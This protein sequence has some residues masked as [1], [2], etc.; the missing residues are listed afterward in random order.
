MKRLILLTLTLLATI[1]MRAETWHV[2]PHFAANSAREGKFNSLVEALLAAEEVHARS[3]FTSR[4][5]LTIKISPSVY[6]IDNPDDP[7][8]RKPRPGENTPFGLEVNIDHLRLIGTGR[9]AEETVVACNRGQTQGA[10][11]NFTM[12]HITGSDIYTENLTFGNYCN[13]DLDYSSNPT[14]S[15]KRRA[16][17]IVQAQL[18]ICNGDR[19]H[20]RNCRFISRLNLCPFAGARRALFEKCHFE[21]T[22][23][24]LCGT[25]VYVGCTFTFFSSKPFYATSPQGAVFLD[26]DITSLC[27]GTQY[28][29]KVASPVAMIDCRW[30]SQH[31]DLNIAWAPYP[32]PELRCYQSNVT[33]NGR[34]ILIGKNQLEYTIDVTDK[35]ILGA[36]K[37]PNNQYNI[38]NLVGG[39]DGWNPLKQKRV[40]VN[41]QPITL[42]ASHR[43]AELEADRDTLIITASDSSAVWSMRKEDNNL[44]GIINHSAGSVTVCSANSGEEPQRVVLTA[45]TP[46]GRE[47]ACAITAKPATLPAPAFRS[48]PEISRR[49]DALYVGYEIETT[50]RR[51]MSDVTW[52]RSG[53]EDGKDATCVKVSRSTQ[54]LKYPLTDA[55]EGKYVYAVVTPRH[56]RSAQ[57]GPRM[58]RIVGPL[59]SCPTE[60]RF[61]TDFTDFPSTLQTRTAPGIWTA[62]CYKPLDVSEWEW[63]VAQGD[64]WHYGE[65]TDGAKGIAGLQQTLRGARLLY[66]PT[67]SQKGAMSITLDV[68]PCKPA[69]QGFGSATGQYLDVCLKFDPATLTGYA[70]RVMRTAR[71]DRKVELSLVKYTNGR[72]EQ[73]GEAR[74]TDLF[75]TGCRISLRATDSELSACVENPRFNRSE[76]LSATIESSPYSGVAIQHTGSTGASAILL[77]NLDISWD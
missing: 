2:D 1:G 4:S 26:C 32:T 17:A 61:S 67:E 16:D 14:L 10:V 71:H 56:A 24:A 23:D 28:L 48:L 7:T 73:I 62:D 75:V 18:I 27:N 47:T 15:R 63:E 11:G 55:D 64:A 5:P 76:T 31:P 22:D 35:P 37:I 30:H 12:L 13:V 46:D 66:T 74:P 9:K 36:Y 49:G 68:A 59:K 33:L 38:A 41:P 54:A 77:T 45:T 60:K 72:T 21:S 6:W 52:W 3:P 53:R 51:D 19:Y 25:G 58:T 65:G 50:G 8:V 20:A 43:S 39:S 34:P 70:L 29:T 42:T 57:G 69:G 40:K 44:L